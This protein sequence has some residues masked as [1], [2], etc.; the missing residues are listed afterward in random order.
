LGQDY[1]EPG[2]FGVHV[3]SY[4]DGSGFGHVDA[5]NVYLGNYPGSPYSVDGFQCGGTLDVT[6]PEPATLCLLG[7]GAL[8]L[9]RRKKRA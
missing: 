3:H 9:I 1:L 4:V 5:T 7:L 2:I 6:I 8:S